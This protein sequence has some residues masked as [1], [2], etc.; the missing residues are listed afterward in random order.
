MYQ[1]AMVLIERAYR[2]QMRGELGEAIDL[3]K[4]SIDMHPTAEAHTFLGWTYS[5]L[6][7][8]EDAIE[9]CERAIAVD[10]S[11]GNP[12]NDIGSYL[13]ELGRHEEAIDWLHD[14]LAAP[15]YDTPH[16]P[17]FNLGRAHQLAGRYATAL[18]YFSQALAHEPLFRPA[19]NA[20]YTLLG[21]LN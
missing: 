6:G 18:D 7:R 5:M 1:Q 15:R 11:F 21:R 13:I 20:R 4:K 8:Q 17:L 9:A 14:A 16:F 10:P 2:A 3:Y 12:Y 19:L